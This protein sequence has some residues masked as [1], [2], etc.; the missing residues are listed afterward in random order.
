VLSA[1]SFS[2]WKDSGREAALQTSRL[3]DTAA[4]MAALSGEAAAAGD[5]T[6]AFS[7]LRAI[8][9]MPDVL[10][11]RID[12]R[13]GALLAEAG[14]GA[15]LARD[16]KLS[17]GAAPS[18][19]ALL[20]SRTVE[21][22]APII[23]ASKPVGRVVLLA[24]LEGA[25]TRLWMSLLTGLLAAAL[26][27]GV[28]LAIAWRL[29][30]RISGPILALTAAMSDVRRTHDYSRPARV[31]A[32]DEVAALVDGFNAMLS[33]IR[34]RDAEIANHV[35][36]LEA[37]VAERTADLVEAKEAAD[38]ANGAKSD[39]LATMSH[40][41]RTPM[42]GIMVMAEMLA[43]GDVPPRQRRF[44]EVIAKSG[45]S[46]LAII[47]DILDFSKIEAGKMDLE[48]APVDP[49]E[50]AEDVCS[51]FWER[52]R[53][54]GLDLAAFIDPA[55]PSIIEADPTRLRQVLGN[56]VNNAIKFT[57]SGGVL[58]EIAPSGPP[59][60]P[61]A[62]L[63]LSVR[64]TGIGIAPDKLGSVFGAFTQADQTT[65][66]KFG[67]TGLG[68]AICKRLV[69]AMGGALSVT[70]DL[71]VGSVFSADIPAT[72]IEAAGDWPKFE[73]GET[74]VDVAGKCTRSALNAYLQRA[75]LTLARAA[76]LAFADPATLRASASRPQHAI[77]LGEYG[78][79][80]PA[81]A[82]RDGLADLVMVQPFRRGDLERV[83]LKVCANEPLADALDSE[84]REAA[85]RL[86]CFTGRRVLVADDSAVNR[87]VALEALS[88]L[89][90][91]AEVAMDG[92]EAV[93]AALATPFDLI[94]MDGSMPQMDGYEATLEIRRLE[95]ELGRERTPIVAL[96]A[97]VVGSAAQAWR[98]ADMDAVLHKP[99]TLASL[100]AV[101]GQF[102]EPSESP[103]EPAP[104]PAAPLVPAAQAHPAEGLFDEAVISELEAMAANGRAGFVER[105]RQLYRDNAPPA[106]HRVIEAAAA[107]HA[108]EA[109]LAAHA[110][111]SMSLNIG[112]RA[113]TEIAA[114]IE[115]KARD[116]GVV[117]LV[118][119]EELYRRLLETLD[120]M[121]PAE[122]PAQPAT[123]ALPET[124]SDDDLLAADLAHA[125]RRGEF[126]LVY[127]PQFARDGLTLTGVECL[128]R[129]THP[130]RG[131][132][133]PA[134]FIPL[135]ERRGLVR[136]ITRWVVDEAL[137][138]TGD[139]GELS[140][141]VN[142]SALEF[143][144]P[145][146]I[147]ELAVIL[148]RHRFD[149]ARLEIEITETAVL[150]DG[151]DVRRNI[152]RLH[153]LGVKI[154]LDDF[155]VGYSSLNH[156]RMFPFDTLK[157][158]RAFV[159]DCDNDMQSATLVHAVVSVGRAMG[160]KVL[161][162]GIETEAQWKF[163]KVAGVHALQG[164]L[165]ARP[166]SLDDLRR[167]LA[168]SPPGA[169]AQRAMA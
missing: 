88:R 33:E 74:T 167:R 134:H 14:N 103:S 98:D 85:Q 66:R 35:E 100:A 43:A 131:P 70:S 83:L 12:R 37:T 84:Q 169:G 89:G 164:Y 2:T 90:I 18:P 53:S 105:V 25:A 94:L 149:P 123:T 20:Q 26:S 22:S 10:Y 156:L 69:E 146:F 50:I 162:E 142:A 139:L 166:E 42:N 108:H 95:T 76:P 67:G 68:L 63:K 31:E 145:T 87:E 65:T 135:A 79:S 80:A 125:A 154:A 101:I 113:V 161:A 132:V 27:C 147:D 92:R 138:Q 51:L 46:L 13:N 1:A 133:S 106:A 128:L 6:R 127:Q 110:L 48:A 49:V 57:E 117:D 39:F 111:K 58:V 160:M 114:R 96:T 21:V 148:A 141:G 71:G 150:G 24:R 159:T 8:R 93:D 158:D 73:T 32:D 78:D 47:N 129:W 168:A 122:A 30:K 121:K 5:E 157:I 102:L 153:N 140:I 155:G 82:V 41:I 59:G 112:A 86:P 130:T 7:S 40:E 29:Q 34:T 11:A 165:F 61:T 151:D 36:G 144:D 124:A 109:A 23:H 4:V 143:S 45:S 3:H 104:Q 56:L 52:A 119:A 19:W 44:A 16:V 54:K 75:G 64:D 9:V 163:L 99:F 62:R 116:A 38:A 15:S 152:A 28:G 120:A 60:D 137:R 136:D 81:Q 107:G 115:S 77:C 72:V 97:H 17:A 55:C 91:A 118:T 126:S